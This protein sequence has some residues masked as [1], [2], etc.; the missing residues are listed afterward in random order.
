MPRN[1]C[2]D[3]FQRG[4]CLP[5][6]LCLFSVCGGV[7]VRL[8][9]PFFSYIAMMNFQPKQALWTRGTHGCGM[10]PG[11]PAKQGTAGNICISPFPVTGEEDLVHGLVFLSPLFPRISLAR[12]L[13]R[14]K[15]GEKALLPSALVFPSSETPACHPGFK[16]EQF[17]CCT[18]LDVSVGFASPGMSQRVP[19]PT[20]PSL[21]WGLWVQWGLPGALGW[22]G[23][24]AGG[25]EEEEVRRR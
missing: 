3:L 22:A 8:K 11:P 25:C 2:A 7:S 15:L 23:G 12:S 1:L 13:E 5:W 10:S 14:P 20:C 21:H 16:P 19:S 4:K 6:S 18:S 17:S 9:F 24:W